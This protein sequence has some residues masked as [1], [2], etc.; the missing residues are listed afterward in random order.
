MLNGGNKLVAAVNRI[1]KNYLPVF[2][3]PA[4]S[5]VRLA[6]KPYL[7]IVAT[8]TPE[9]HGAIGDGKANDGP[10]LRKAAA[11]LKELGGGIIVCA[12]NKVYKGD[13]FDYGNFR[14]SIVYLT[15][16]VFID[17]RGST[18]KTDKSVTDSNHNILDF[19]KSV[20]CGASNGRLRGN[21]SYT[22][23][24][25]EHGEWGMGIGLYD[26][27]QFFGTNLD[28]E[29]CNGDAIYVGRMPASEQAACHDVHLTDIRIKNCMRQGMTIVSVKDMTIDNI[30]IDGVR[31]KE[32]GAGIDFEPNK[33]D[34]QLTGIRVRDFTCT[35]SNRGLHFFFHHIDKTTRPIDIQLE[36]VTIEDCTTTSIAFVSQKNLNQTGNIHFKGATNIRRGLQQYLEIS[37][38]EGCQITFDDVILNT[39]KVKVKSLSPIR[40]GTAG[41]TYTAGLEKVLIKSLKIYGGLYEWGLILATDPKFQRFIRG[42]D[43]TITDIDKPVVNDQQSVYIN[44]RISAN[45]QQ[46]ISIKAKPSLI[47]Y[48]SDKKTFDRTRDVPNRITNSSY[49]EVDELQTGIEWTIYS[50]NDKEGTDLRIDNK[51]RFLSMGA[52]GQSLHLVGSGAWVKLIKVSDTEIKTIEGL[53]Y[54]GKR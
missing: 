13:L 45:E 49:I 52:P 50:D 21:A 9:A 16:N 12:V 31:G 28:I 32:P 25:N 17:L 42:I 34:E 10:A 51:T 14:K 24:G 35:D 11:H 6:S 18:I 38:N 27:K 37:S 53:G 39:D 8:T 47:A 7:P 22:A 1:T 43:I 44:D 19:T 33:P 48:K 30:T 15:D 20:N 26:T 5:E 46:P 2:A 29:E 4:L 41:I 40:V 54:Y 36:N 23:T 3:T